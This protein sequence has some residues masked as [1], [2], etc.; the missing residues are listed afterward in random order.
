MEK[1]IIKNGIIFDPFNKIEGEIK[2]IL[3]EDGVIV[4]KFSAESDVKIIDAKD[5]TVIPAALEIHA[6]FAAQQVN[7]ARLLGKSN[8]KFMEYWKGLTLE[9]VA[10]SYI[11]NGYT[12]ILEAS[13]FPSLASQTIFNFKQLP[14]LDKAMLLN[15]S[16]LWPLQLEFQRGKI[17]EMGVFL[18]DMLNKTKGFGF[19]VYNPFESED[20]NFKA[21]RDDL[22]NKGK[23][24]NFSALAVYKNLTKCNEHLGLPHSIHAHIEGYETEQAKLNLIK[25]LE[26]I[27]KLNLSSNS[28]QNS[29]LARSQVFHVAHASSLNIDGNN[30]E[31]LGHVNNSNL[32]DLDLGFI[33]FNDIN[34]LIT[35]DRRL[36]NQIA[37]SR[38]LDNSKKIIR[39]AVEFEGDAFATLRSFDKKNELHCTLW[40]NAINLA[41]L[42]K[43]KW[44]LQFSLNY[45]NYGDV[46]DVPEIATWLLSTDARARFV[47]SL[48]LNGQASE[49]INE[50]KGVLTFNDYVI[51]TRESP[52]KSLGLGTIKGNLGVDADGDLNILDLNMN[53]IEANK[54]YNSIKQALSN[55]EYVIKGGQVI[56]KRDKI[57]LSTRGKIFHAKQTEEKENSAILAKKREF[58]TKFGSSFYDSLKITIDDNYLRTID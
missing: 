41:L 19:K 34:P 28:E 43:N 25:V 57:D 3:I 36:I 47:E 14:V 50:D 17:E 12:F 49:L 7:W 55:I 16:N 1:L 33:S 5:K 21:L 58:Y 32:I 40:A 44:Q 23:L 11:A 15:V 31:L 10:K 24:Y 18:S 37:K 27:E 53:D 45:P 35:S 51:I 8:D 46:N 9:H 6:H 13:V 54:D 39:S 52:A 42:V 38:E 22:S 30:D 48:S 2:D 4:E 29:E 56:K 26:M 20:W